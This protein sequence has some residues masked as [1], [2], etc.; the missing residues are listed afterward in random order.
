M[1][2]LLGALISAS[3]LISVGTVDAKPA[4][5]SAPAHSD[6]SSAA[7]CTLIYG[8]DQANPGAM[9][10]TLRTRERGASGNPKEV[11]DAYPN[12][13]DNVGDLIQQKCEQGRK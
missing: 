10:Q 11:A 12:E 6:T 5:K 7:A 3:A 1:K 2:F 9:L 4:V 8:G 13:F